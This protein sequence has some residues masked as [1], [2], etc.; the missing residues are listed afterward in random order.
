MLD[1]PKAFLC[2]PAH[3]VVLAHRIA[4]LT[5]NTERQRVVYYT[6]LHSTPRPMKALISTLTALVLVGCG[7]SNTNPEL[8]HIEYEDAEVTVRS[9]QNGDYEIRL[10]R[11]DNTLQVSAVYRAGTDVFHY[12]K[13][14][15]VSE[16]RQRRSSDNLTLAAPSATDAAD[17]VHAIWS[18]E[19]GVV[20]YK[21]DWICFP[22]DFY[23]GRNC[24]WTLIPYIY[25]CQPCGTCGND[26]LCIPDEM[27]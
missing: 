17:F 2:V 4:G 11:P 1:A 25:S 27:A 21:E 8:Q 16:P 14:D 9:L 18:Y 3:G 10:S 23:C 24:H 26:Y 12:A 19:N 15:G 7:G 13:A 22:C 6:C 5:L 20:Q